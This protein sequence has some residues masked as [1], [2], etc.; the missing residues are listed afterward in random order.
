MAALD[1]VKALSM[2]DKEY[3]HMSVARVAPGVDDIHKGVAETANH[4]YTG[5]GII[6][7]IMDTGLQPNH[8]NFL[9]SEGEPRIKRLFV[10]TGSSTVR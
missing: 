2:G 8:V 5:K 1:A 6:A 3:L 10:I 7:G 9:D 4:S